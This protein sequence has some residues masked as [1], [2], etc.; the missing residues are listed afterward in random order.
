MI[1]I[2]RNPGAGRPLALVRWAGLAAI[3]LLL[4]VVAP[5]LR[6]AHAEPA[7]ASAPPPLP[8]FEG[9]TLD[10]KRL[11]TRSF[12]G[13]RLLLLCFNPGVDQA[14]AYARALARVAPERARHNFAIVGVA[15][16][17]DPAKARAF[18]TRHHLDFP[19]FDDSDGDIGVALGLQSPL[20]LVGADAEGR[21][22][23]AVVGTAEEEAPSV[24]TLEARLRE[25]LRLPRA[26]AAAATG[27]LDETPKAPLFEAERL[28][29]GAPI[30]LAEHAGK[31]VVLTFFL[32][33]CSHCQDAL[34][35]FRDE[36]ARMP[37]KARPVFVGIATDT[38]SYAVES[39]LAEKKLDFFPAAIDREGRISAAYGSFARVP[40]VVMIDAEGRIL[41]RDTGWDQQ[42]DPDLMRM[43]LARLVGREAPML[44]DRLGY[45][46]NDACAVC[47]PSQV[48]TW[49]L[50]EHALAFDTLV[51][52]GAD[53]DP[54]CI[55][56][57]V[58]GFGEK[59]GFSEARREEHLENVGCE[60]CHGKGGGHLG[61][62]S[63]AAT[64]VTDYRPAC[65]KCHDA[66]HSLGFDYAGFL[67]KVSHAVL[68]SLGDAERA[69]LVAQRGRPR[70][71][72]PAT[73]DY[74][75]SSSCR[76]CH[77]KE[78]GIWSRS[79][80]AHS[81]ESLARDRKEGEAKCL[82]CHVTGYAKPGGFPDKGKVRAHED[83]ARVGCESCH[84]PGADHVRA[85]GKQPAGIV[86]LGDKCDSCVILQICGSCHDDAND[87]GFRFQVERK[88]DLQRH[89]SAPKKAGNVGA[90][91]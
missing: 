78:Y 39:A 70:D 48:A 28:D 72:L 33:G 73:S 89:G 20:M 31:P 5:A 19:I 22:G 15:M 76:S 51:T 34:R 23:L 4:G 43:R 16:G 52:R 87:P 26:G 12:P 49:R 74:L 10:G 57:H 53:R 40:D 38:R 37:E 80:H 47:H 59:G 50:T 25:Y 56:C 36:L 62:T 82:P 61:S 90:A 55:G 27:R 54:K 46:G 88:I 1:R 58:V 66:E 29:G 84:G 9:R 91:H 65:A 30:R 85:E 45:S 14:E 35:F 86:R 83:L 71:L 68:G 44:L 67:P 17:L 32:S 41:F 69:K 21:V 79:A 42:R 8:A 77:E 24:E 75:G 18:A 60:T 7:T 63:K 6:T 3:A 81:V 64:H 13:Q 11:S 2:L